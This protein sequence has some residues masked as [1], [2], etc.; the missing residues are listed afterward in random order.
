LAEE[1]VAVAEEAVAEEAAAVGGAVVEAAEGAAR[2]KT[3]LCGPLIL[4]AT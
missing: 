1:V 3:T 4:T 2:H